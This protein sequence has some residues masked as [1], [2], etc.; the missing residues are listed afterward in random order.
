LPLVLPLPTTVTKPFKLRTDIRGEKY[1]QSFRETVTKLN[2]REKEDLSFHAKPA[3]NLLPYYPKKSDKP[4]TEIVEFNLHTD[5]RLEKRK[6]YDEKRNL[7]E[8]EEKILK[9]QKQREEEV[10]YKIFYL[11]HDNCKKIS[12]YI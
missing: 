9:E 4:L 3:P 6:A 2:K 11:R 5:A 10:R 8:Q 7:R 12:K 1:Q